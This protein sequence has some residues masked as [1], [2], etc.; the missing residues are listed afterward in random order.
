MSTGKWN[1]G[2]ALEASI[3]ALSFSVKAGKKL[4]RKA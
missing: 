1:N 4:I 3:S 2:G